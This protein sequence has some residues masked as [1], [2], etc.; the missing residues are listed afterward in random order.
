[1]SASLGRHGR[2]RLTVLDVPHSD[3]SSLPGRS[4]PY[5][6]QQVAAA[7]QSQDPGLPPETAVLLARQAEGHLQEMAAADGPELAR[8]LMRSA[9]VGATP[10]NVVATAAVAHWQQ[11]GAV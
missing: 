10:A 4:S 1:M 3:P 6:A 11:A 9:D 2:A 7:A 8:R 5:D